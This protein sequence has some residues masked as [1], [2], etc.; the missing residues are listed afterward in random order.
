MRGSASI[1]KSSS[2]TLQQKFNSISQRTQGHTRTSHHSRAAAA[3]SLVLAPPAPCLILSSSVRSLTV[4]DDAGWFDSLCLAVGEA[5][6]V[7]TPPL[8]PY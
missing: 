1:K 7:M 8:H 4:Y 2:C 6:I 5:V 3:A